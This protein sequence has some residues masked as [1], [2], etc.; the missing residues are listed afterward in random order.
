[1]N[2]MSTS[3]LESATK[4]VQELIMASGISASILRPSNQNRLYGSDEG[5]FDP[6]GSLVLELKE[7]P[8]ED[9]SGKIDATAS[10]LPDASIQAEDHLEIQ[11]R[12][13]RIQTIEPAYFFGTVTHLILNLVEIHGR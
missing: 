2:L 10:V 12:R 6:S 13:F 3:E 5:A 7:E 4:D 11:G 8:K 1:M 9:L